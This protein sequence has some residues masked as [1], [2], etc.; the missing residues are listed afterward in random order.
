MD[1]ISSFLEG[2]ADVRTVKRILITHKLRI[3]TL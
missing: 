2:F 1:E 3:H